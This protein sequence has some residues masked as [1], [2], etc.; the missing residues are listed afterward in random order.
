[1]PIFFRLKKKQKKGLVLV[2][3]SISLEP[4]KYQESCQEI[5]ETPRILPKNPGKPRNKR[6]KTRSLKITVYNLAHRKKTRT[7]KV[8]EG[9]LN[10]MDQLHI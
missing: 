5:Q 9:N 2:Q 10:S 8:Q 4:K 6:E 7:T 3:K 1:M